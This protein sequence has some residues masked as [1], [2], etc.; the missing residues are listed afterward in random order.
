MLLDRLC[1]VIS[2]VHEDMPCCGEMG[3]RNIAIKSRMARKKRQ[4]YRT[5]TGVNSEM[6]VRACTSPV[7]DVIS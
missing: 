4:I 6:R 3:S 2:C 7:Q 1:L 5:G